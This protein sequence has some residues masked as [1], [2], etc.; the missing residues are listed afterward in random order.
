VW[1]SSEAPRLERTLRA[2]FGNC[3]VEPQP[4]T[5]QEREE[6]YWLYSAGKTGDEGER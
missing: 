2:V 4:V 3:L 1:S 6:T 5:L